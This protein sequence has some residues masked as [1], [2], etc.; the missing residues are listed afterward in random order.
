VE[1][2]SHRNHLKFSEVSGWTN[3]LLRGSGA[4]DTWDERETPPNSNCLTVSK[5]PDRHACLDKYDC[6]H[7]IRGDYLQVKGRHRGLPLRKPPFPQT[8]NVGVTP[9]GDPGE[10]IYSWLTASKYTD[11]HGSV[12]TVPCLSFKESYVYL[13]GTPHPPLC[14]PPSF[15]YASLR[16]P[17]QGEGLSRRRVTYSPKLSRNNF[18]NSAKRASFSGPVA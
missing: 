9:C 16:G 13:Y 18:F 4:K 11:R 12:P 15:P 2:C 17:R 8:P 6:L 14:G 5:C 10:T 1:A 3:T 7:I